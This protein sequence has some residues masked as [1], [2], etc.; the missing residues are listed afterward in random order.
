M[1]LASAIVVLP[2]DREVEITAACLARFIREKRE[3]RPSLRLLPNSPYG[4]CSR[5]S[6]AAIV[7][8]VEGG[9]HWDAQSPTTKLLECAQCGRVSGPS[10]AGWRGYRTDE[11]E[12][13][14]EPSLA[15]FCPP[16]AVREFGSRA[17][18]LLPGGLGPGERL[19]DGTMHYSSRWLNDEGRSSRR[20]RD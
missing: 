4:E 20:A 6:G 11:P 10:A 7:S 13:A 3:G 16:C 17:L 8:D 2:V 9:R 14:E 5:G 18:R 15:F 12:M 1:L 19:I